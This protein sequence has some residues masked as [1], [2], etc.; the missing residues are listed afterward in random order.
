[1]ESR[2]GL[3][4]QIIDRSYVHRIRKERGYNVNPWDTHNR[5][6]IS[7]NLV[8]DEEYAADLRSWL[9][10]DLVR[11]RTLLILDEAH[12]AAPAS[13]G[14]TRSP[15][16]SPDVSWSSHRSSS[17]G[18]SSPPRPITAIPTASDAHGHPR[19]PAVLPGSPGP[20][21]GT[22]P[23]AYLPTEGRPRDTRDRLPSTGGRTGRIPAPVKGTPELELAAKLEDYCSLRESRLR[24]Q[25]LKVRNASAFLKSGLQQRLLSSVEAFWRR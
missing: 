20:S 1:M 6:I 24:D 17:T 18:S 25:P 4:F 5:F 11:P 14:T 21:P 19:P 16:S 23:G 10:R 2:F 7:H 22:R 9:G 13:G 12:H 3:L 15:R 8:K